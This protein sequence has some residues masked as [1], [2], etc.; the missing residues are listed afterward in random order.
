MNPTRFIMTTLVIC[1]ALW[2]LIIIGY[3]RNIN[4]SVSRWFASYSY[5]PGIVFAVGYLCGHFFGLM[6]PTPPAGD[7]P[8]VIR[9]MRQ[10]ANEDLNPPI[11][12]EK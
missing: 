9:M 4:W 2:D 7:R 5:Y 6:T 11:I 12:K 1:I 8:G 3:C 10:A